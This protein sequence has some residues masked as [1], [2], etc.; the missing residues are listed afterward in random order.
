[1]RYIKV[2][3]LVLVFFLTMVFLCQN[4]V[5][6]SKDVALQLRLYVLPPTETVQLPFYLVVIAAFLVGA[7]CCFLLLMFDRVRMS[8]RAVRAGWRL[9]SMQDEKRQ[10]L[11]QLRQLAQAPLEERP[12]LLERC[13]S[14]YEARRK[15]R[16]EARKKKKAKEDASRITIDATAA[17]KPSKAVSGPAEAEPAQA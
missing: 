16:I 10:M 17:S 11:T 7:V 9:R 4:Q 14:E 12:A 13:R 6:L 3:V 1:M 15:A 5:A 2:L 8:A